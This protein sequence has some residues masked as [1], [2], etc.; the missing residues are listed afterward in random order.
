[1]SINAI[2]S[3]ITIK[4]YIAIESFYKR[5]KNTS[6]INVVYNVKIISDCFNRANKLYWL[7]GGR[8]NLTQLFSSALAR[9]QNMHLTQT[10][11]DALTREIRIP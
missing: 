10:K 2:K 4:L 9:T 8:T 3:I 11:F 7:C 5:L 6:F 1:M